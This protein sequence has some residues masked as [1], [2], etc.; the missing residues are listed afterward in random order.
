MA[1]R[2]SK[3]AAAVV[4]AGDSDSKSAVDPPATTS[5]VSIRPEGLRS[6]DPP[7]GPEGAIRIRG[8]RTHNLRGI[9]VDIPLGRLTAI[10]GVSGSGKSS[11]AVGTLFAESRRRFAACL[12]ERE[13]RLLTSGPSPK[14]DSIDG[15]PPAIAL[16]QSAGGDGISRRTTVADLADLADP[17][18]RLWVAEGVLA[19]PQCGAALEALTLDA[20]LDRIETE[21]EGAR[22]QILAPLGRV[23]AAEFAERINMVRREG[24]LRIRVGAEF[25]A[26]DPPPAFPPGATT[27]RIDMVVDRQVLR[28]GLRGRLAES[29]QTAL[30]HGR[31]AAIVHVEHQGIRR[32]LPL[33]VRPA[34]DDCGLTFEEPSPEHLRA[35]SGAGACPGC[36]GLGTV[37]RAAGVRAPERPPLEGALAVSLAEPIRARLLLALAGAFPELPLGAPVRCWPETRLADLLGEGDEPGALAGAVAA[38]LRTSEDP[39][40]GAE[41]AAFLDELTPA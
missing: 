9:D 27:P 38:L 31:G 8:A 30:K 36:R 19:C 23:D 32:D 6:I 29:L 14:F 40:E 5:G 28:P 37:V 15:L 3:S 26:I 41:L 39:G 4:A 10:V 1:A 34:C 21:P 2:R 12:G 22:A 20:M 35:T 33:R 18:E 24:F 13:R 25:L 16:A 17:L 7:R 11:L